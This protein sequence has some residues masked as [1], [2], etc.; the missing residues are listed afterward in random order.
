MQT[1]QCMEEMVLRIRLDLL[2]LQQ[3][4]P[5]LN[6]VVAGI[7]SEIERLHSIVQSFGILNPGLPG[8]RLALPGVSN[9]MHNQ[10]PNVH[11]EIVEDREPVEADAIAEF[12]QLEEDSDD[13]PAG[14]V[15]QIATPDPRRRRSR[16]RFSA[17]ESALIISLRREGLPLR[18]I[19]QRVDKTV[20]QVRYH[21]RWVVQRRTPR[22][23][24]NRVG[25]SQ[26]APSTPERVRP[27]HLIENG[28]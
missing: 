4:S 18:E 12:V 14:N 28:S 5:A 1:F 17:A 10:G 16:I 23:R 22:S 13:A 27:F 24:R 11:R 20:D 19:A 7:V 8:V 26:F 25:E 3:S 2:E 15:L 21:W 9:V 6:T